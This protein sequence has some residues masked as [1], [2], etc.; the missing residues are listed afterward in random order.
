MENQ[1]VRN[2]KEVCASKVTS[3]VNLD[4]LSRDLCPHLQWFVC[5]SS[6]SC[7]RGNAGQANY[8]YA[9][10]VMER[11]C[12]N[13]AHEGL[14]GLAIQWGPIGDCT[15]E[16]S[17]KETPCG[18]SCI[19][20][21]PEEISSPKASKR[22][23]LSAVGKIFDISDISSM[24]K[25]LSLLELGMDSLIEVELKLLLDRECD[26]V[27]GSSE[28]RKLT[29]K[30]L[31]ILEGPICIEDG[32]ETPDSKVAVTYDIE[33]AHLGSNAQ[34]NSWLIPKETIVHLNSVKSGIPL[35][36]VHPIEGTVGMLYSLAQL[37]T[38]PVFGIQYTSE[39][40]KDSFEKVA[41]WYWAVSII[42]SI[43]SN[44]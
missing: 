22:S 26:L 27:L 37:I 38:V 18:L 29:I 23:I 2:F 43:Y 3:T 21:L 11:I 9:N 41:V 15:G 28:L 42:F 30:D 12:E 17:S 20:Y 33:E 16:V 44:T 6:V 39:A 25:E 36:V 31:G 14:P 8:G 24:N 10:S 19:P 34:D 13:R 40:P 1:T 7:G 5:F 35:F 32:S 4:A